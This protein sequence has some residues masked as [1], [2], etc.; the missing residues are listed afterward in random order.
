MVQRDDNSTKT[1]LRSNGTIFLLSK[2]ST[3]ARVRDQGY[4]ME[5]L[6]VV[7]AIV[8]LASK[9]DKAEQRAHRNNKK[10]CHA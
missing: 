3:Q 4:E 1:S 7:T 6:A 8:N 9:I 2:L 10:R 5:L